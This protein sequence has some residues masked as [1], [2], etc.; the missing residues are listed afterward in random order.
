MK[1]SC[2][3][4]LCKYVFGDAVDAAA[5]TVHEPAPVTAAAAAAADC[6]GEPT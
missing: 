4:C 6:S 1:R 2:L 5:G 3:L